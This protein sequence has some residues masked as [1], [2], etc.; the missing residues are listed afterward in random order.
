M[1]LSSMTVFTR[2]P[3]RKIIAKH[4]FEHIDGFHLSSRL[5]CVI[6]YVFDLD[7]GFY[8]SSNFKKC[9]KKGSLA[10][11]HFL[12]VIKL[13]K[14][15][16][17][18]FFSSMTVY[19]SHQAWISVIKYVFELGDGYTR[20]QPWKNVTKYVFEIGDGFYSSSS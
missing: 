6:K 10:R 13:E 4:F 15:S 18:M 12:R 9:H 3:A 11:W 2:H 8:S 19:K 7:G 20:H 1:F 5:K 16:S 17:N 14:V